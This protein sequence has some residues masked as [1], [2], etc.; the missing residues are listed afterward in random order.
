VAAALAVG[1]GAGCTAP[2]LQPVAPTSTGVEFTPGADSLNDPYVG[3]LGNG[4]YDVRSYTLQLHYDPV[5]RK[6]TGHA[7]ITATATQDLSRFTLDL[8]KLAV[9]VATVDGRPAKTQAVGDEL[10]VTPQSG[11]A[12]GATFVAAIDYA[13]DPEPYSEEGLGLVGFLATSDGAFAVGEPQV[14]AS[15]YPS[16]DYPSDKAT[17]QISVEVPSDLQAISN[18]VLTGKTD[19]G[20]WTTWNWA[21]AKP[22][23]TYLATVVIGKYRV[24]TS[25]HDGLPVIT[26]VHTSLPTSIDDQLARTPEIVDFLATQF[27]PYPVDALGGIVPAGR[28]FRFALE[29]QTRPIYS[30]MFFPAGNGDASWVIAHELAHQWF[31]DS[32]SLRQWRDVWLNEG[33]ATY[34]QWLW[35]EH[36][37]GPSAKQAFERAYADAKAELWADPPGA[38]TKDK[39]FGQSVYLRGGLTLGALRQTVGDDAFFRILKRWT[40]E[41]AGG[42]GTTEQFIALAE[43]VSG[44]QLDGFFQAWLYNTTRPSL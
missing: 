44:Q 30:P 24:R 2:S 22:M 40:A 38:P 3:G 17:Y 26:A 5:A 28:D 36:E 29:N 41:R 18:G 37:G 6:L 27:G 10:R 25:T 9:S 11:I 34:A 12:S 21:E 15:W 42:N 23:A 32:V 1:L 39:L 7:I 35:T 33:P 13:G 31:G 8:R 19:N 14:A 4:G 16:N 43:E 20:G